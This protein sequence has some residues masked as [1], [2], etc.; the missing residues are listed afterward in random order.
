MPVLDVVD[1]ILVIL[2]T[3]YFMYTFPFGQLRLGDVQFHVLVR[4][5]LGNIR[6]SRVSKV[7]LAP[8]GVCVC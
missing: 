3:V 2:L 5:S 1:V 7:D 8:L 6:Y 4:F